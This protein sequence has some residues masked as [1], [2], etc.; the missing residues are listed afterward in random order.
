[1]VYKYF[2]PLISIWEFGATPEGVTDND[3]VRITFENDETLFVALRGE[4]DVP[5]SVTWRLDKALLPTVLRP[6]LAIGGDWVIER[7]S[8]RVGERIM[9]LL[10]RSDG[11]HRQ[12]VRFR[13]DAKIESIR[14]A[15]RSIQPQSEEL[16]GVWLGAWIMSTT[17]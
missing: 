14:P 6:G 4:P 8:G 12:D 11:L 15:R 5:G 13:T 1:M 3:L 2:P 7:K 10:A 9:L 16:T 17:N